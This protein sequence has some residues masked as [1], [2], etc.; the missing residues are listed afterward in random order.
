MKNNP[1]FIARLQELSR[2][3]PD[4]LPDLRSATTEQ[5]AVDKIMAAGHRHGITLEDHEV[6]DF[7]A[8]S[9]QQAR[10]MATVHELMQAD[11][12]LAETLRHASDQQEAVAAV[13]A[14]AQRQGV[15]LDAADLA[16]PLA[17][18]RQLNQTGEL[19]DAALENVTGGSL[20]VLA[21]AGL[22]IGSAIVSIGGVATIGGL[23][24][25][26]ALNDR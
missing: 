20:L 10:I 16:I 9:G 3:A 22:F 1:E 19:D 18:I 5:E 13:M 2:L 15:A 24:I 6:R 12:G 11:P 25:D 26:K 23:L 21:A 17:T 14:V 8:F 7:L 4:L